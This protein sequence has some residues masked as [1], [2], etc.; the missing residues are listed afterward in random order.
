[1]K[2]LIFVL[3]TLLLSVCLM[4]EQ[5]A[6]KQQGKS[7]RNDRFE[8]KIEGY[9]RTQQD[10]IA[11]SARAFILPMI[12]A[13]NSKLLHIEIFEQKVQEKDICTFNINQ[14]TDHF[15]F[16]FEMLEKKDSEKKDSM[17][18][19]EQED[20][21]NLKFETFSSSSAR[22]YYIFS[23]TKKRSSKEFLFKNEV[24]PLYGTIFLSNNRL[25]K[26]P[27]GVISFTT[28]N[29]RGKME[30]KNNIDMTVQRLENNKQTKKVV[31]S[32]KIK[33]HFC[34]EVSNPTWRD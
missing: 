10:F 19:I 20:E 30:N 6:A 11:N 5:Q 22:A 29:S 7:Q 8:A 2:N 21:R 15:Q 3:F 9:P 14:V 28:L 16:A 34:S 25:Y 17:F 27:L 23:G 12:G 13:E 4:A 26:N 18:V 24:A 31:L 1:M 32:G 33:V